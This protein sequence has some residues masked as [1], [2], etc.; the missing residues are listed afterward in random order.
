MKARRRGIGYTAGFLILFALLCGIF[1]AP[2]LA[3]GL[4]AWINDGGYKGTDGLHCC[5]WNDCMEIAAADAKPAPDG[6]GYITPRGIIGN[7]GV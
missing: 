6:Q 5:G 3:H 4:H 7:K 1:V 2:A